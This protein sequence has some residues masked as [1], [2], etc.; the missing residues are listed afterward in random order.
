L[1]VVP[2][3]PTL[4]SCGFLVIRGQPIEAFLLMEHHDRLDVPK[5]HVDGDESE[6]QCAL[7]ELEEETAITPDDIEVVDGFRFTHA[8]QVATRRTQFRPADKTLVVFLARLRHDVPIRPTE[9]VGYRWVPWSPP[10]HMQ[11]NT[12][13]PLLAA[14]ERFLRAQPESQPTGSGR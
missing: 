11:K 1:L 3:Y 4:K 13:D 7:R 12:I 2:A 9:H 10:H 5:G 8:Y 6:L 14:V